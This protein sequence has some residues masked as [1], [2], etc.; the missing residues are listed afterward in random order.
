MCKYNSTYKITDFNN[1]VIYNI[2]ELNNTLFN[3]HY[4][5]D[6]HNGNDNDMTMELYK[7]SDKESL[8]IQGN[9]YIYI[10]IYICMYV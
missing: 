1:L 9:L 2:T 4:V 8:P 7:F 3:E 6:C 10:Y 5:E